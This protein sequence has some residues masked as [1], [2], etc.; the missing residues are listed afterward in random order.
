MATCHAISWLKLE[1]K[2]P[3]LVGDPLDVE[4]FLSTGWSL[5]EDH[6]TKQ[7]AQIIKHEKSGYTLNLLR[8]FEFTS[9]RMRAS[10][11]VQD[12]S[13]TVWSFVKGAPETIKT[14]CDDSSVPSDFDQANTKY[15]TE[16]FRVIALAAKKIAGM[17]ADTAHGQVSFEDV[18]SGLTF[19]GFLVIEN[20]LKK[21]TTP[22]IE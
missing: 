9:Q 16:G 20:K 11:L 2:D 19:V 6:A 10:V 1:G 8:R 5:D 18:E 14:L 7:I 12:S 21:E 17:T 13:N 4:M 3:M 15:A 22:A